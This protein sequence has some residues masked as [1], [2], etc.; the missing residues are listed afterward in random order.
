M[1]TDNIDDDGL[2]SPPKRPKAWGIRISKKE[3]RREYPTPP[4]FDQASPRRPGQM[5]EYGWYDQDIENEIF[6]YLNLNPF[7]TREQA[8]TYVLNHI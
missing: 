2:A 8:I 4:I 6:S 5:C 3:V 1:N 7:T